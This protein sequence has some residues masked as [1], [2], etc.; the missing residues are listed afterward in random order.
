MAKSDRLSRINISPMGTTATSLGC[1]FAKEDQGK[2]RGG[3]GEEY[4][5][6]PGKVQRE[7][8]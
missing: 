7:T 1:H 8:G 2:Y 3:V 4:K 6:T 5:G